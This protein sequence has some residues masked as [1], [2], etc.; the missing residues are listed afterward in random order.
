LTAGCRND[1]VALYV[2]GVTTSLPARARHD[3]AD[4]GG[5]QRSRRPRPEQLRVLALVR[6]LPD[7]M[8]SQR[9]RIEQW[10]PHL[11]SEHG[12]RVTLA[13]FESPELSS[14]IDS[15][16][17]QA[18]KLALIV[19]DVRRR[20][21]RRHDVLG[22]DA[23]L[24]PREATMIGAP[25]VERFIAR[26]GVPL[27]YDFDDAVWLRKPDG[28]NNYSWLLRMPWKVSEICRLATAVTVGNEHLAE[29]ARRYNK[30]VSIVRTSIDLARFRM[31]PPSEPNGRF[32]IV[33]TGSRSTLPYLDFIR[34]ALEKLG[35]RIP[36]TLRVVCD[37]PP[38]P[39]ANVKLDFVR[40]TPATEVE[41]LRD[42][43][44]GI[45][46]LPDT[47]SA[48]GKCACKALQYMAVGRAA[49]VSPVGVNTRIVQH[50]E[51]GIL[52]GNLESWVTHL[53]LLARN[54][55]MRDRLAAAGRVTVERDF[56]SRLSARAFAAAVRG[57]AR[58][59]PAEA[60]L[61]AAAD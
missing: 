27:I 48:R 31:L 26:S 15:P 17:R 40:W 23:V 3:G 6:R 34:P 11:E 10:M 61:T 13:P 8:P 30:R 14:I 28:G 9:F 51:N 45:M 4:E 20:W 43:D 32:R 42:A 1:T 44:V 2:V 12:I 19:R 16:G 47:P 38:T 56:S 24:V 25:W 50:G 35:E 52:A 55:E 33:W 57:A 58:S 7:R 46:P 21:L 53:E 49:I 36:T 59:R 60:D 5:D 22:Y 29:Y 37:A 18:H 54:A 41:A 39:F